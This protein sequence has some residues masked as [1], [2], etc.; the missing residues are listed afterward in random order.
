MVGWSTSKNGVYFPSLAYYPFTHTS[1]WI[2]VASYHSSPAK[3]AHMHAL[4][5]LLL[6]S[7]NA[8]ASKGL[9]LAASVNLQVPA[10]WR[11]TLIASLGCPSH[12][13]IVGSVA[14]DCSSEPTPEGR[15]V[16]PVLALIVVLG[17]SVVGSHL[18]PSGSTISPGVFQISLAAVGVEHVHAHSP[19]LWVEDLID[20]GKQLLEINSVLFFD[21]QHTDQHP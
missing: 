14:L 7:W 5:V 9:P 17:S 21:L 10:H 16:V 12:T 18:S 4:E 20:H 15:D 1:I 3:G 6:R 13:I 11:P 8:S 2:I 19:L